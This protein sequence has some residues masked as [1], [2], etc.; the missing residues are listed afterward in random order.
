MTTSARISA[1]LWNRVSQGY[2]RVVK[3]EPPFE[4]WRAWRA[5]QRDHR[6]APCPTPASSPIRELSS[7]LDGVSAAAAVA[8]TERA[9]AAAA[10]AAGARD[11]SSSNCGAGGYDTGVRTVTA[12][13]RM[14]AATATAASTSSSSSS[15]MLTS[16]YSESSTGS[17]SG[18]GSRRGGVGV[19]VT[20]GNDE[21]AEELE[22]EEVTGPPNS[23][24]WPSSLSSELSVSSSEGGIISRSMGGTTSTGTGTS[25]QE[26][27]RQR[28]I[29]FKVNAPEDM[30]LAAIRC[31]FT[32]R[33]D[34]K[35]F[36]KHTYLPRI[37][38]PFPIF[39]KFSSSRTRSENRLRGESAL[40]CSRAKIFLQ[41][42]VTVVR[43]RY[44]RPWL[45]GILP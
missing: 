41:G 20:G 10:A 2:S 26:R 11:Y 40:T 16:S 32:R 5:G 24:E 21:E 38:L 43:Y 30:E 17:G 4:S 37:I 3:D 8:V 7:E 23:Q 34:V 27:F 31:T 28:Q 19:V 29:S 39:L 14:L 1:F 45:E 6:P 15:S 18:S 42:Q 12:A 25:G 13:P 35:N 22:Y 36:S 9:T 33:E 44:C